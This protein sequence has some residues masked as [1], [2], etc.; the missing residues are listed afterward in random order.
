MITTA[1]PKL[2]ELMANLLMLRTSAHRWPVEELDFTY[3]P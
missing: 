2:H 3:A 1:E